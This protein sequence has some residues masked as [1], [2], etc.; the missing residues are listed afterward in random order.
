[1]PSR[2]LLQH[3]GQT[4]TR[5]CF[6]CAFSPRRCS[7]TSP[8]TNP[9]HIAVWPAY[10]LRPQSLGRACSTVREHPSRTA[11]STDYRPIREGEKGPVIRTARSQ[12]H[13][14]PA[15]A[16]SLG[17]DR[18]SSS[19]GCTPP[20]MR[21]RPCPLAAGLAAKQAQLQTSTGGMDRPAAAMTREEVGPGPAERWVRAMLSGL[22]R[23]ARSDGDR[24]MSR[25]RQHRVEHQT[26]DAQ[27]NQEGDDGGAAYPTQSEDAVPAHL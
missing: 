24:Q 13:S 5:N 4:C 7:S 18:E 16:Q 20:L 9:A 22:R 3:S 2:I 1:M 26:I 19:P 10:E 8:D 23:P 6:L 15:L 11:T 14:V 25:Q 12:Q 27:R 21:P 17:Q